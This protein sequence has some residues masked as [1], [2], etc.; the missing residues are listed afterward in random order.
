M[1]QAASHV[2]MYCETANVRALNA[3]VEASKLG[4]GTGGGGHGGGGGGRGSG[5]DWV[6]D[7]KG[8]IAAFFARI[9]AKDQ[10]RQA[11][12]ADMTERGIPIPE[13]SMTLWRMYWVGFATGLF[14][15]LLIGLIFWELT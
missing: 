10:M 9:R 15:G 6:G 12:E 3:S 2:D 5:I 1:T 8:A 4:G 14:L 7:G 11:I 13:A